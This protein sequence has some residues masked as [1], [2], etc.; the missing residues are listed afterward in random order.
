MTLLV[1]GLSKLMHR[2]CRKPAASRKANKLPR[3]SFG[4]KG[5]CAAAGGRAPTKNSLDIPEGTGTVP[6]IAMKNSSLTTILLGALTV[7][8]IASIV[9]CW[10]YITNTRQI[11]GMQART[12]WMN[13][14]RAAVNSLLNDTIEYSK[15]NPAVIPVLESVGW[16]APAKSATK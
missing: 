5:F 10:S 11:R 1:I 2:C 14:N 9:L 4:I 15:R 3:F 6:P 16:K 12:I 8:A 7:S 13:N